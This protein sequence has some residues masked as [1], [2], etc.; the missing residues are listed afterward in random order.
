M[1]ISSIYIRTFMYFYTTVVGLAQI[2]KIKDHRPLI[3]PMGII[4]IGLSQIV[5]PDIVHSTN[6]NN[7]IWPIFSFIFTI[8]LP[9]LLLIVA[10][11][12]NR[13]SKVQN[14]ETPQQETKMT[15]KKSNFFYARK[16]IR[17]LLIKYGIRFHLQNPIHMVFLG[18]HSSSTS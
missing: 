13:K 7:E 6:Y 14:N 2:L 3:L 11:I 1:W 16:E 8:L 15:I 18:R 4:V 17:L 10:A 12:R 9:I 5:H